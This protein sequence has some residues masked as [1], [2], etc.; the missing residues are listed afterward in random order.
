MFHPPRERERERERECKNMEIEAAPNWL[1]K[2][3]TNS[4]ATT[5]DTLDIHF[6]Q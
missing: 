4:I 3:K 1:C 6:R 2:Q 5:A